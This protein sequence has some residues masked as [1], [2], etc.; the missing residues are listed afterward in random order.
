MSGHSKMNN[1]PRTKKMTHK[2]SKRLEKFFKKYLE[3]LHAGKSGGPDPNMN[4]SLRMVHDK[5][6]SNNMP[7]EQL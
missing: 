6:K 5:A 2:D 7:N 4:P 3:K 1:Y